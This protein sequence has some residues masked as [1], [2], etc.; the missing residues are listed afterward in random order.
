ML[1]HELTHVV[2][3]ESPEY[4][5]PSIQKFDSFEHV[6]IGDST[7]IKYIL[8]ESN[9]RDLPQ[10][11]SDALNWPQ[12]YRKLYDSGDLDQRRFLRR[13]LTYG[14]ILALSGDF[15]ETFDA[16]KTAP[17]REIYD[18]IPLIRGKTATTGQL[19]AATGGRYL[20]LAERNSDFY[21]R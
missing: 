7:R 21:P 1:A 6:E 14:E 9:V 16:L 17:L 5:I 12:L 13:G 2:Q 4:P 19:Q 8:L 15:Y 11:T 10:R 3:Q 18:L 20:A